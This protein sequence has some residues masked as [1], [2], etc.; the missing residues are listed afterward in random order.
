MEWGSP[1]SIPLSTNSIGTSRG[2]HPSIPLSATTRGRH[3]WHQIDPQ[4][5]TMSDNI[6]KFLPQ[7]SPLP[8]QCSTVVARRGA[9]WRVP[10]PCPNPVQLVHNQA[11]RLWCLR[12]PPPTAQPSVS[13]FPRPPVFFDLSWRRRLER[14]VEGSGCGHRGRVWW[15]K[16][17]GSLDIARVDWALIGRQH[18]YDLR[19]LERKKWC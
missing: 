3:R 2:V 7:G 1:S 13:V 14:E 4:A 9:Q 12:W 19:R 6:R 8:S 15:G 5:A 17:H 10:V 16:F 18:I 11:T